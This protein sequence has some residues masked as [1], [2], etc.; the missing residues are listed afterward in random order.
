MSID[1]RGFLGA[2]ALAPAALAGCAAGSASAGGE[3]S[4][5]PPSPPTPPSGEPAGDVLAAV[6]EF[7]LGASVEPALVFRAGAARP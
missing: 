7:P 1:R 3:R 2:L 6:R 4:A 5:T